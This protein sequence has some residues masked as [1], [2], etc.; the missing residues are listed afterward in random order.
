MN[1]I[2][3][4]AGL[5]AANTGEDYQNAGFAGAKA[6]IAPKHTEDAQVKQLQTQGQNPAEIAIDL[7][8]PLATVNGDLFIGIP[9]LLS[10]SSAGKGLTIS[11]SA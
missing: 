11:L 3:N 4:V 5:A 10:G 7:D 9:K 2:T 1:I 6:S 8:I